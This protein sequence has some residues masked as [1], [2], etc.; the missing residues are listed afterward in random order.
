MEYQP[1]STPRPSAE[2]GLPTRPDVGLPGEATPPIASGSDDA[3]ELLS[4]II[5][6]G[7]CLICLAMLMFGGIIII[8]VMLNR[9]NR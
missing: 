6:I 2:V 8:I 9:R 3:G 7:V 1:T 5:L 4:V